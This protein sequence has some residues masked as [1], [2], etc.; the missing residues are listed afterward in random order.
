[1]DS[2][3]NLKLRVRSSGIRMDELKYDSCRYIISNEFSSSVRYCGQ[4]K[5]RG[6][7]CKKHGA[8]CY[9]VKNQIQSKTEVK[10]D[11]P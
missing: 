9:I 1:M 8:L 10:D 3:S 4:E 11:Q 6:A 2:N 5:E 7:Y